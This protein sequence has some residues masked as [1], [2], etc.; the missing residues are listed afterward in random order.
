MEE[1]WKLMPQYQGVV[2]EQLQPLRI[3]FGW[4]PTYRGSPL[5]PA[6]DRVMQVGDASGIQSPLR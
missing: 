3:L 1:Y 2:L 4:F 6:F 5:R